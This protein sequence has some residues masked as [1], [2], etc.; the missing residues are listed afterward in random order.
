MEPRNERVEHEQTDQDG[1]NQGNQCTEEHEADAA[2]PIVAFQN[3]LK[4][5]IIFLLV[6]D[7]VLVITVTLVIFCLFKDGCAVLFAQAHITAKFANAP[8]RDDEAAPERVLNLE[9]EG[10]CR[11]VGAV[12]GRPFKRLCC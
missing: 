12:V 7:F 4:V 2:A 11:I 5:L 10:F 8:G 1:A 6:D 3:L 9:R